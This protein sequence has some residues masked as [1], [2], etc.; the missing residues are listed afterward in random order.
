MLA[1]SGAAVDGLCLWYPWKQM[2]DDV[3]TCLV[4]GNLEPIGWGKMEALGLAPLFTQPPFGGFGSDFCSGNHQVQSTPGRPY[5]LCAHSSI[6]FMLPIECMLLTLTLKSLPCLASL[7]RLST[8]LFR[9]RYMALQ[10]WSCFSQEVCIREGD[11]HFPWFCA[12][13]AM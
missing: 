7:C 13:L 3:I 10:L 5:A 1:D 2:R 12:D 11:F 8:R 9:K 4:T 6:E